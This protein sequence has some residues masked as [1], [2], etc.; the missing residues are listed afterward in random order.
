MPVLFPSLLPPNPPQTTTTTTIRTATPKNQ[1]PKGYGLTETCAATCI[2]VP[3]DAAQFETVGPPLPCTELRF[4]SVPDMGYN[5]LDA[6]APAGEVL[7]RGPGL[8]SGYYKVEA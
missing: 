2:A 7:L 6:A 3:D 1:K 8:F 4:E 5:A